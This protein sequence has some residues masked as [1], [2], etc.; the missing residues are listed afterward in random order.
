LRTLGLITYPLYLTHNVIGA[1]IIRILVDAGMDELLA[2]CAGL[3]LLV[4]I[5]WFICAKVEPA[6][7]RQLSLG[8]SYA[9]WLPK[10]EP[11]P[12]LAKPAPGLVLPLPVPV[13]LAA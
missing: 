9:G 5:C 8:F 13:K 4:F 2:V 10:R 7:R 3:G 6:V 11:R 1:A 12:S